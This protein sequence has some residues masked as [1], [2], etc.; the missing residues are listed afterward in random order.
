MKKNMG[1]IDRV[2]RTIVGIVLIALVFVGPQTPW[3]WLNL[4]GQ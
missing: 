2:L 4:N 3:G 1:S